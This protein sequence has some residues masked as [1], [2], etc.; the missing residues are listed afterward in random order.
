MLFIYFFKPIFLVAVFEL[1][2]TFP[3]NSFDFLKMGCFFSKSTMYRHW[4]YSCVQMYTG[5]IWKLPFRV[6]P[7]DNCI[8][9]FQFS[10][11]D[12]ETIEKLFVIL[13]KTT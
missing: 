5:S 12:P 10:N 3:L 4:Y 1:K 6:D 2:I 11:S 13:K 9:R 8:R 7:N